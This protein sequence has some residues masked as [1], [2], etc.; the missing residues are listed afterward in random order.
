[1]FLLTDWLTFCARTVVRESISVSF[2][3]FTGTR[4]LLASST[5][6]MTASEDGF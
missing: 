5:G 2:K 3:M 6:T 1:M 4:I